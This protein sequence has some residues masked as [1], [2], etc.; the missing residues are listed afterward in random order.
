MITSIAD[1]KFLNKEIALTGDSIYNK[2][3]ILGKLNKN[4][5]IRKVLAHL[6]GLRRCTT[7]I[8]NGPGGHVPHYLL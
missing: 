5:G 1:K 3:Y 2:V 8:H 6:S 4:C 7:T